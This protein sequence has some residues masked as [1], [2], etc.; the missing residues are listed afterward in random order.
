MD[1]AVAAPDRAPRTRR[2]APSCS[3][4]PSSCCSRRATRPSRPGGSAREGRPQAAARPLLL[5]HDGRPLP[6]GLPPPGRGELRAASSG[7]SRPSRRCARSGARSTPARGAAFNHRVR[8]ARQPPQGDPRRDRELRR[9]VP[10][11]AARGDLVDPRGAR[12]VAGRD[13]ARGG[14]R[15]HGRRVAAHRARSARSASAAATTQ[16]LAFVEQ[17]LDTF[18]SVVRQTRSSSSMRIALPRRILY[19]C[20]SSRPSSIFSQYSFEFGHVVSVCG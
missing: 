20:S 3:T 16:T 1:Y 19:F 18:S 11:D 14:A 10:R 15:R 9:T 7:R 12:T 5:P 2:P 13:H 8:R 17:Y 4:R 6:R